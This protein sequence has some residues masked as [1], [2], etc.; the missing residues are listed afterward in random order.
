MLPDGWRACSPLLRTGKRR[1]GAK[2]VL[3]VHQGPQYSGA[4]VRA[5][6]KADP[7]NQESTDSETDHQR[8][9]GLGR[10]SHL[11]SRYELVSSP[12]SSRGKAHLT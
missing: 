2:K 1:R 4:T 10:R 3:G 7:R 8:L 9:S 12:T 5:K 11:I 6:L